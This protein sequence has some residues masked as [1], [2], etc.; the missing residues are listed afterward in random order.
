MCVCVSLCVCVC[1]PDCGLH[2]T[3]VCVSSHGSMGNVGRSRCSR[4]TCRTDKQT[5]RGYG[6]VRSHTC[7]HTLTHFTG[8]FHQTDEQQV[9][10]QRHFPE[11]SDS[12]CVCVRAATQPA[13]VWRQPNHCM[14][15][16]SSQTNHQ[17]PPPPVPT[18]NR[19]KPLPV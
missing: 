13:A 15:A 4:L 14:T 3:T 12:V 11:S 7:T 16:C 6:H 19:S 8:A 9:C 17:A 1:V 5:D 2:G 18:P 10:C